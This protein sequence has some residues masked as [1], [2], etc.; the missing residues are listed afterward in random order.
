LNSIVSEN[1]VPFPIIRLFST[2]KI[3]LFLKKMNLLHEKMNLF[4]EK[5]NLFQEKMN[6]FQEKMNL[7]QEKMDLFQEKMNLFQEKMNLFP[8]KM[9]LFHE[10][11]NLF[12]EKMNLFQEKMDLFHEKMDLSQ[13]K[14]NLFQEKMDLFQEK[15][16]LFQEKMDLFQ[17]KMDLFQ[18]KMNLF[19][20]G[21]LPVPDNYLRIY[22]ADKGI[23]KRRLRRKQRGIRR[24]I[25]S[26]RP[27]MAYKLKKANGPHREE[28]NARSASA[29]KHRGQ[30]EM[31]AGSEEIHNQS[32]YPVIGDGEG[33]QDFAVL[34]VYIAVPG[35]R[36]AVLHARFPMGEVVR[37][38]GQSGGQPVDIKAG[39][40]KGIPRQSL[41]C[42]QVF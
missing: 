14:M 9:D 28:T 19:C 20:T 12:H 21:N 18:E 38:A 7:F 30:P 33:V 5:M 6:L 2:K 13:E 36:Q 29:K 4:Q 24:T 15:M 26:V 27:Q 10:K 40:I 32:Q 17:E 39:T 3:H 16:N 25:A 22:K 23:S 34:Q 11:M 31:M 42:S 35:R 37:K 8:E 1:T 41:G